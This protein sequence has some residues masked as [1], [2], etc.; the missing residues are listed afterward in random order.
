M[1]KSEDSVEVLNFLN[2]SSSEEEEKEFKVGKPALYLRRS[3][4]SEILLL[5]NLWTCSLS[6]SLF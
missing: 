5:G 3:A 1:N 2:F 6:E 4:V